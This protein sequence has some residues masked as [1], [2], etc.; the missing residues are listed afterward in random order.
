M[1]HYTWFTSIWLLQ[2]PIKLPNF[3]SLFVTLSVAQLQRLIFSMSAEIC[4]AFHTFT[5]RDFPQTIVTD[6][7]LT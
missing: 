3:K 1:S 7:A 2:Y 4:T 5:V 6:P